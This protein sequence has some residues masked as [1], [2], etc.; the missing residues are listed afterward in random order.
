MLPNLR[1]KFEKPF[2]RFSLVHALFSAILGFLFGFAPAFL[3]GIYYEIS[4][5][6][7]YHERLAKFFNKLERSLFT[8]NKITDLYDILVYNLGGAFVGALIRY[9]VFGYLFYGFLGG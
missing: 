1:V 9:F 5:S 8:S 7:M 3:F 2:D 6:Y 4:Q